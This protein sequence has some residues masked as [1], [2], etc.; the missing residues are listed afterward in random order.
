MTDTEFRRRY[1]ELT[2]TLSKANET[3]LTVSLPMLCNADTDAVEEFI[4]NHWQQP[5][6]DENFEKIGHA[7]KRW[8]GE[9]YPEEYVN[10]NFALGI[11]PR[12]QARYGKLVRGWDWRT[13]PE[14]LVA[15][16]SAASELGIGKTEFL[17]LAIDAFLAS[18][19][20]S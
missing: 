6:T 12:R 2:A 16:A 4:V 17:E 15:A 8:F 13:T 5:V 14:R 10:S 1:D 19:S 9:R 11:P 20:N 3:L 7:F 18:R